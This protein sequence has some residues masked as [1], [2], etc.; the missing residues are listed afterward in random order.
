LSRNKKRLKGHKPEP[1]QPPVQ[2]N[3]L[4]FV[5]PTE[6]VELPS[7]GEFYSENH[8]LHRKDTIEIRYMTAKDE[9]ILTSQTLL[10]KGIAID[11]FI[12]NVMI[13]KAIKAD[14][15][16]IGD[17]NAIVIAARV[18]GYGAEYE[19]VLECPAC[20]TK[21]RLSFDLGNPTI[22]KSEVHEKLNVT[23]NPSG[24]YSVKLPMSKYTVEI[25][26]LTGADENYLAQ[27]MTSNRKNKLPE[28]TFTSH[29][30]RLLVS[31]E[32]H[33]DREILNAFS[34]NMPAVDSRHLRLV[35]KLITPNIEIKETLTCKSCE[36]SEEVDVPFG[37]DFFWPKQ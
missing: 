23:K 4:S 22:I 25:R 10:K 5:A 3:P 27:H 37:A 1:T 24:T 34:E 19:A 32:G 28:D 9:D 6:F 26:L 30:K 21:N 29:F 8:P 14:D 31:I 15:L 33:K 20:S 12:E 17:K 2:L 18:S 7:G 13:D 16:L 36:H 11:R 35:N